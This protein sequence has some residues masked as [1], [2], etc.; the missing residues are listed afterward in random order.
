MDL[1]PIVNSGNNVRNT[2]VV[3]VKKHDTFFGKIVHLT[4]GYVII[5]LS[6]KQKHLIFSYN[7]STS[8]HFVVGGGGCRDIGDNQL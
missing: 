4:K 1:L 8:H 2:I 3:Q 5:M 6:G 7:R